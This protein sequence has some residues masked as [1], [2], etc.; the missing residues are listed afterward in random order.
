MCIC[1]FLY[2][3]KIKKYQSTDLLQSTS[4]TL[5]LRQYESCATM[6]QNVS[7]HLLVVGKCL[8]HE[9]FGRI[10]LVTDHEWV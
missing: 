8:P 6:Q 9:G 5:G 2:I 7:Y 10:Q 1:L 3:A 4:P